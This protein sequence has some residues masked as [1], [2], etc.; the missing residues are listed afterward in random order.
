MST[1]SRDE[2]GLLNRATLTANEQ[3]DAPGPRSLMPI[4]I[5]MNQQLPDL[6]AGIRGS[7]LRRSEGHGSNDRASIN[8]TLHLS[9]I[10]LLTL[11]SSFSKNHYSS[12]RLRLTKMNHHGWIKRRLVEIASKAKKNCM[13]AFSGICSTVSPSCKPSLILMN[14]VPM[15]S[16]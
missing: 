12:K 15:P 3:R 8:I 2:A 10:I 9:E 6:T 13:Y 5:I 1:L 11:F 16:V 7:H 14:S 4:G